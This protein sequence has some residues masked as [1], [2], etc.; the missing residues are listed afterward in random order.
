MNPPGAS[1]KHNAFSILSDL[2]NLFNISISLKYDLLIGFLSATFFLELYDVYTYSYLCVFF[3]YISH[4]SIIF[5][6][7]SFLIIQFIY[8]FSTSP[9]SISSS[10]FTIFIV[11][12]L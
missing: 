2:K 8:F 7:S 12:I 6:I 3:S 4:K 5:S 11:H 9:I 1:A 10:E